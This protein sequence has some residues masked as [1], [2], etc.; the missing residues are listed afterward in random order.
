MSSSMAG[1]VQLQLIG[2][3]CSIFFLAT[4]LV[5]WL[6]KGGKRSNPLQTIKRGERWGVK[7]S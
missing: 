6:G 7:M 3:P 1:H 5:N 4:N 2:T